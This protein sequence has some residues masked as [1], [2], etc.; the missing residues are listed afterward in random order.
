ML[1]RRKLRKQIEEIYSGD[2]LKRIDEKAR[3][4]EMLV[5]GG[6]ELPLAIYHSEGYFII[7]DEYPDIDGKKLR[8]FDMIDDA[9]EEGLEEEAEKQNA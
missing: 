9:I 7:M 8:L 2:N 3:F 6:M 4:I 1:N 5:K